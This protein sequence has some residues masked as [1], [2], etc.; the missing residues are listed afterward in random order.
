MDADLER[1]Y[2]LVTQAG[3]A[4]DVFGGL[5]GPRPALETLAERFKELKKVVNLEVYPYQDSDDVEAAKEVNQLLDKFYQKAQALLAGDFYAKRDH[6]RSPRSS[7]EPSFKTDK[8]HYYL[9]EPIAHGTISTVFDAECA[10]ENEFLGRVAIKIADQPEDNELLWRERRVLKMLFEKNGPQLK[11]L[12]IIL[13]HFKTEDGRICLVFRCLS[14][15]CNFYNLRED[16]KNGVDRKHMVWMLN[17]ALSAIGYAHSLGVV[18]GNLDPSHLMIRPKD[19]NLF[20]VDWCWSIVDPVRT[21]D[22]FRVFTE[23]FS[24]PEV[25]ENFIPT[26]AADLYSLGKCMI[27]ILGG[28][29]ETNEMPDSVESDLQRFIKYFVMESPQQR[30]QDAWQMHGQLESLVRRLWGKK[31]FLALEVKPEFLV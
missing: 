13:D 5:A 1:V 14:E 17:R 21:H 30:A 12:P 16:Y 3:C 22:R 27:Y 28:N 20:I 2:D 15:C 7:R 25:Q 26:P 19:H 10:E 9:G 11:H 6:M 23:Y 18:H 4:E 8:F 29:V 31:R 24:A